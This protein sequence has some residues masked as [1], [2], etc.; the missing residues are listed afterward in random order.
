MYLAAAHPR[1]VARPAARRPAGVMPADLFKRRVY[2]EE[3][4][5]LGALMPADLFTSHVYKSQGLK[6][7]DLG[8]F[9]L[10]DKF[11]PESMSARG[12]AGLG[13]T[14]G[15]QLQNPYPNGVSVAGT[16]PNNTATR[17]RTAYYPAI[18]AWV[19]DS[20]F[21]IAPLYKTAADLANMTSRANLIPY[22]RHAGLSIYGIPAVSSRVLEGFVVRN[23]PPNPYPGMDL[24]ILTSDGGQQYVWYRFDASTGYYVPAHAQGTGA[25]G[26]N[27]FTELAIA[28][29]IIVAGVVTYGAAAG[30]FAGAGVLGTGVSAGTALTAVGTAA[31]AAG[32]ISKLV[33][34]GSSAPVVVVP[35]GTA[36]TTSSSTAGGTPATPGTVLIG[37]GGTLAPGSAIPPVGS[38]VSIPGVGT[39]TVVAAPGGGIGVQLPGGG[40]ESLTDSS[41]AATPVAASMIPV[42]AG[43]QAFLN[44]VPKWV[45]FAGAVG[46]FVLLL[47]RGRH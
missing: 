29:A 35:G 38:Q 5:L 24:V 33:G 8:H 23:P 31:S 43:V 10:I 17:W 18:S 1:P 39:G 13:Q 30:W 42:P 32:A 20:G 36:P 44:T 47:P 26:S 37:P 14:P 19:A 40:Y 12:I 25:P 15:Q 6:R 11:L 46:A 7:T 2:G 4:G 16:G 34:G 3:Q 28:G 41:G 45:W 27:I 21:G 9:D 22:Y